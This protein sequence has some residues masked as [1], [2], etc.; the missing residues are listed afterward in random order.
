MVINGLIS[1]ML[2]NFDTASYSVFLSSTDI[3]TKCL[4]KMTIKFMKVA[5]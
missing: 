3:T 2:S 5:I 4:Y 1:P